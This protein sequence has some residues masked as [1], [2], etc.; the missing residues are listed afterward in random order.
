MTRLFF[1]QDIKMV[2]KNMKRCKTSVVLME[3]QTSTVMHYSF[4][5]T[6]ILIVKKN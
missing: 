4:K 2:N 1:R 5:H 3:M 6:R